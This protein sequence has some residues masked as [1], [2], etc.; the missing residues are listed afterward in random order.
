MFNEIIPT[1][2]EEYYNELKKLKYKLVEDNRDVGSYQHLVGMSYIDD[3]EQFEFQTTRVVEYQGLIVA[4]RAMVLEDGSLGR[5]EKS[6]IHVL[7]VVRMMG[8]SANSD[9]FDSL[10]QKGLEASSDSGAGSDASERAAGFRTASGWANRDY[11]RSH[12]LS[13]SRRVTRVGLDM[14]ENS[15]SVQGQE[16]LIWPE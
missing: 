3:E 10:N 5:E 9:V 2:T 16:G 14:Q 7:D 6:P 13:D 11:S 8:I 1:Y 4:Y 12:P 15:R